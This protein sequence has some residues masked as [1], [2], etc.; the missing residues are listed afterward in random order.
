MFLG[1]WRGPGIWGLGDIPVLW[2]AVK[3]FAL[4]SC[5]VWIRATFP[6]LRYDRLMDFGWKFLLP[7]TLLWVMVAA[8]VVALWPRH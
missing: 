1:G 5:F 3:V 2:F 8:T 7:M 4:C 6:R